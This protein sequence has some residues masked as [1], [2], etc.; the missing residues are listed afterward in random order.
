MIVTSS[1]IEMQSAH[2]AFSQTRESA[3]L[4]MWVGERPQARDAQP[5]RTPAAAPVALQVQVSDEARAALETEGVREEADPVDADPKLRMLRNMVEL[6]TG[7]PVR[8]FRASDLTTPGSEGLPAGS[9]PGSGTPGANAGAGFGIEFDYHASHSE[10]EQVS[11][12][13]QGVVRTADGREIRFEAGFEMSRSLTQELNISFR[14]GDAR[15]KDPLVLDFGGPSAAL[16]DMR[17]AFDLDADGQLDDIPMLAGG[18]GYLAIDRNQ[19]N[20]IDDG[21]ELFGPTTGQGFNELAALDSDG[22]GWI[23][24]ADP[25]YAQL[26]IWQPDAQGKGQLM[27][28][29]DA[30]V[31]ALYLNNVATPFELRGANNDTLGVMRAS[32]IYLREDGGVGTVSQ[33]DLSV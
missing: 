32:S 25:A 16:S 28:L 27:S 9:A 19:N 4:E 21:S 7:K 8:T 10:F 26:R 2:T 6:L 24:E 23:D 15:L 12:Q 3:R 30:G 17:F 22:N 13:A 14:A 29:Q 31:G 33:I 11:F 18:R 1:K 20:L 5:G